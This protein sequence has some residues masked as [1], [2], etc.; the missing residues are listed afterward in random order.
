MKR[1][2]LCCIVVLCCLFLI[3]G[4]ADKSKNDKASEQ[5]VYQVTENG[6]EYLIDTEA[7]TISVGTLQ[8]SYTFSGDSSNYDATITYPDGACFHW[9]KESGKDGS[10]YFS[11]GASRQEDHDALRSLES[12][13]FCEMLADQ[14]ATPARHWGGRVLP[15]LVFLVFGIFAAAFPEAVWYLEI[16]WK[17]RDGRPSDLALKVN[18]GIGILMIVVAILLFFV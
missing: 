17:Q 3:G 8:Y 9:T 12:Q 10:V 16:G 14:I 11:G 2:Y 15:A 6:T 1:T 4:C 5:T 13:D 7:Q 18:T